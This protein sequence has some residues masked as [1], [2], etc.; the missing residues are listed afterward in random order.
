MICATGFRRGFQPRPAARAARRRARARDGGRLDRACPRLDRPRTH[1][2]RRARSRSPA[3][4]RSGR[5]RRRTPSSARSTPRAV[6]WA[7]DVVHAERPARVA[8]RR[9]ARTGGRGGLRRA[10]DRGVVAARARRPDGRRRARARSRRL[11]PRAPV[12]AGLGGRSARRRGAGARD[13]A[14]ARARRERP[15]PPGARFFAGAWLLAQLL[16]HAVFPTTRWTYAEDGGELG[17]RGH[18]RS[19]R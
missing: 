10:L 18:P 15:A 6:F 2:R 17:R 8:P 4:P 5:T 9:S 13:G 14:R 11:P 12:P 16:A 1:R 7:H 3:R 19:R